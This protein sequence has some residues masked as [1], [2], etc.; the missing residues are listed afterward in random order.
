MTGY[1]SDREKRS[2]AG[3][4]AQSN[5]SFKPLLRR[6]GLLFGLA[7]SAIAWAKLLGT[8]IHAFAVTD[9]IWFFGWPGWVLAM[10]PGWILA[11]IS[12]VVFVA[13][14]EPATLRLQLKRMSAGMSIAKRSTAIYLRRLKHW[15]WTL[16]AE[17]WVRGAVKIIGVA[18]AVTASVLIVFVVSV[19][20]V[21]RLVPSKNHWQVTQN[22]PPKSGPDPA[23]TP[24]PPSMQPIVILSVPYMLPT[25][26]IRSRE[27]T[28]PLPK[29]RP[30]QQARTQR[31]RVAN[32]PLVIS[33]DLPVDVPAPAY[34]EPPFSGVCV[35][36][37]A[38]VNPRDRNAC[39][40]LLKFPPQPT[41]PLV[42][43]GG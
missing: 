24:P 17:S 26:E 32:L 35:P 9:S 2:G 41:P 21:E 33:P 11:L 5:T 31:Q 7:V 29:A 18:V 36:F 3:N 42:A 30:Q 40:E 6:C 27:T 8:I 12:F 43:L 13:F 15:L 20:L 39:T 25:P 19:L 28:V 22:D 4:L 16:G 34:I 38:F 37:F 23:P 14:L 10:I 1:Q